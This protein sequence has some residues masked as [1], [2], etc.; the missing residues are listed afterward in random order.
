MLE[1][2]LALG[3][4]AL[5]RACACTRLTQASVYSYYPSPSEVTE[6]LRLARL[7]ELEV[8]PLVQTFGHMEVS[9][10]G[11]SYWYECE[12]QRLGLGSSAGQQGLTGRQQLS[13]A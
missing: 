2:G 1:G 12:V 4:P 13:A 9:G 3:I 7:S 10:R 5:H 8:I 11:D 6:I